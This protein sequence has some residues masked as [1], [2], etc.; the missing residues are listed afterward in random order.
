MSLLNH[1]GAYS[2]RA[3]I[4]TKEVVDGLRKQ[5]TLVNYAEDFEEIKYEYLKSYNTWI[6]T[7]LSN[8]VFNTKGGTYGKY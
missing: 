7:A 2:E 1:K 5:H 4:R 6:Y 8:P 3:Q